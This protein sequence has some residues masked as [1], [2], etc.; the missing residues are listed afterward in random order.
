MGQVKVNSE[1][2]SLYHLSKQ[3]CWGRKPSL[4]EFFCWSWRR[5]GGRAKRV[6]RTKKENRTHQRKK[7]QMESFLKHTPLGPTLE[8][9]FRWGWECA[10]A[11][12]TGFLVTGDH[13]FRK[14][15]SKDGS[16]GGPPWYKTETWNLWRSRVFAIL[17]NNEAWSPFGWGKITFISPEGHC[18]DSNGRRA[19]IGNVRRACYTPS[20]LREQTLTYNQFYPKGKQINLETSFRRYCFNLGAE[21]VS[22]PFRLTVSS[23]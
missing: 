9:L 21:K 14:L 12:L 11:F 7:S 2:V 19:E 18:R 17:F 1:G 8:F 23:L 16:K 13:S 15:C 6:E 4:I 5:G 20:P 22:L 10:F 3:D